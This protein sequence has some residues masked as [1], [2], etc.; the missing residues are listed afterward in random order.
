MHYIKRLTPILLVS[1]LFIFL[2]ACGTSIEKPSGL[3]ESESNSVEIEKIDNDN[4]NQNEDKNK[5]SK[6]KV[7]K[8]RTDKGKESKDSTEETTKSNSKATSD[9]EIN[10]P[11]SVTKQSNKDTS[12]SNSKSKSNSSTE[13]SDVGS[14][15]NSSNSS[16]DN[17]T[18]KQDSGNKANKDT[19]P[20]KKEEKPK[21]TKPKIVQSI[22]ISSS[23]VPLSPTETE[24]KEGDKPLN[25]LITITTKN[26]IQM[27]YSGSGGTAYIQGI[28]NVYEFDRGQGS[29]WMYRINGVF[30]DRGAGSVPLQDGDRLEWLYTQDL[31][32][33]LGANLQPF[34]R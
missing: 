24:I 8:D 28:G 27:D 26:G 6:E 14:D 12:K 18:I 11:T 20:P 25:A 17:K 9:K 10:N 29:G 4:E 16:K 2:T 1:I 19:A 3:E 33:D 31:G 22:V 7:E 30:P 32:K 13:K 5:E 23:E 15:K 21:E 34:R